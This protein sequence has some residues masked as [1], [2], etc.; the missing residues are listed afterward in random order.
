MNTLLTTEVNKTTLE[1]RT[2]SLSV[3]GLEVSR[4]KLEY[5][6][7][8]AALSNYSSNLQSSDQSITIVAVNVN[9]TNITVSNTV[10]PTLIQPAVPVSVTAIATSYIQLEASGNIL[11][12]K[13][14][15]TDLDGRAIYADS[16]NLLHSN[17]LIGLSI[18][19]ALNSQVVMVQ[20]DM[21]LENTGWNWD[22]GA[23]LY[24]GLS[25]EVT[26]NPYTG[27]FSQSIGYA[28]SETQI[29]IRIGRGIILS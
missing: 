9:R 26:S 2:N 6:G 12:Y 23:L 11:A 14:V 29:K 4:T 13:V 17:R 24:L 25:G 15:T 5:Y 28:V 21:L 22:I 27:L 16:S 18:N 8:T 10:G 20:E 1:V 3:A 7:S 19:S